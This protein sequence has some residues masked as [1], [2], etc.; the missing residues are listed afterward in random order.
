MNEFLAKR[1]FGFLTEQMAKSAWKRGVVGNSHIHTH[2][3][4]FLGKG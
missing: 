2:G 1:D 3:T 4:Y